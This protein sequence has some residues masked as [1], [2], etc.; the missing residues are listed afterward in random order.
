MTIHPTNDQIVPPGTDVAAFGWPGVG[1]S[2]WAIPVTGSSTRSANCPASR[3]RY[4]VVAH[5]RLVVLT[6]RGSDPAGAGLAGA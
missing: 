4:S 5:T 1:C 6:T 2:G 3:S